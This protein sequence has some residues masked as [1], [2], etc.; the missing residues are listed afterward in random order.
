MSALLATGA[1]HH[2]LVRAEK[3][4]RVGVVVETGEAREVHHHC[5]LVGYGADAINPYLAFE[6]LWQERRR[7][8]LDAENVPDDDSIVVGYRKAVGQGD[9]QGLR[10][11]GHLDAAVLQGCTDL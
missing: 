2:H 9:A 5:C 7:G 3:R 1:V 4:T 8:A 11:D 6:A 10:Q